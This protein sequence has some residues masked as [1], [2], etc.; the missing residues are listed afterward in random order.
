MP[1]LEAFCW[2]KWNPKAQ[3]TCPS[4][5]VFP[6]V[7][8]PLISIYYMARSSAVYLGW[9]HIM[10]QWGC[11]PSV[12]ARAQRQTRVVTTA[13]TSCTSESQGNTEPLQEQPT[14]TNSTN[15][16][17]ID[18]LLDKGQDQHWSHLIHHL[19]MMSFLEL[20][21]SFCGLLY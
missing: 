17:Q 11:H 5:S 19:I 1:G 14:A 2:L 21:F 8:L 4:Q 3:Q 18:A 13:T 15:H 16:L 6:E 7:L 10:T 9:C 20:P 12:Q